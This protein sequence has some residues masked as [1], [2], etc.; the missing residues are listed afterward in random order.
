MCLLQQNQLYI[1]QFQKS[2]FNKPICILFCLIF[3]TK[4][5]QR[6]KNREIHGTEQFRHVLILNIQRNFKNKFSMYL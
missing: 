3:Y 6:N 2:I 4:F 5:R 1:N